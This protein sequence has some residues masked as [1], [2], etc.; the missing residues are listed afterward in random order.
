MPCFDVLSNSGYFGSHREPSCRGV[1]AGNLESWLWC[2][3]SSGRCSVGTPFREKKHGHPNFSCKGFETDLRVESETI[4]CI[5]DVPMIEIHL[6]MTKDLDF[7]WSAMVLWRHLA[8]MFLK[9]CKHTTQERHESHRSR[10]LDVWSSPCYSFMQFPQ[11]KICVDNKE[12]SLEDLQTT[13]EN[14]W[15]T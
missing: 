4:K 14:M 2:D 15:Q 6:S 12:M 3:W 13:A 10:I 1:K 5:W 9:I 8:L 7:L 11:L